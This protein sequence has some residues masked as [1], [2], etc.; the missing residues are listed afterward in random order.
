MLAV[1]RDFDGRGRP[2][3]VAYD[4]GA[5]EVAKVGVSPSALAFGNQLVLTTSTP[6]TVT[7]SNP[8]PIAL[9][10]GSVTLTGANAADFSFVSGCPA[11]LAAGQSCNISVTFTPSLLGAKLASLMVNTPAFG[12]FNVA[13]SGAGTGPLYSVTPASLSFPNTVVATTSSP[14]SVTV[15]NNQT[16]PMSFTQVALNGL[17]GGQYAIA[18]GTTCNTTTTVASGGTCVVNVTFNPQAVLGFG[19]NR[20]T[21]LALTAAT[22]QTNVALNGTAILFPV[23]VTPKG[24]FGI[25]GALRFPNQQVGTAGSALIATLTNYQSTPVTVTSATMPAQFKIVSGPTTT[26]TAGAIVAANGGTCTLAIQFAPT[27]V[28]QFCFLGFCLP[29]VQTATLIL[30]GSPVN[31]TITLTGQ[32]VKP[33]TTSTGTVAFAPTARGAVSATTLVTLANPAGNLNMTGTSI[34]IGG[35]N[36]AYFRRST[37][38]AGT[39]PTTPTFPVTS[40]SSC[41]IGVEFA[42]PSTAAGGTIGPKGG[43][44]TI[45]TTSSVPAP[46]PVSLSGTAN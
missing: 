42:P 10:V 3:G 16:A 5:H 1:T 30:S 18:T 34:A 23:D 22:L 38:T 29:W 37:T 7:L 41:T 44:L 13:L 2:Q 43:T 9:A 33:A 20:P 35:A 11:N 17:F 21:N 6:Q 12:A 36:A 8:R 32:A 45:A 27:S 28:N 25:N 31:P 40:G 39:C 24:T 46:A 19:G 14:L 15:R 4:I 26:C